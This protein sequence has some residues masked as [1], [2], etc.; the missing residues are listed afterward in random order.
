MSSLK[1]VVTVRKSMDQKYSNTH[2]KVE[3]LKKEYDQEIG[4]INGL[5]NQ[6]L[7]LYKLKK[8]ADEWNQQVKIENWFDNIYLFFVYI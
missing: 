1:D 7:Y 5:R 6:S 2:H 4:K 8:Y 3:K